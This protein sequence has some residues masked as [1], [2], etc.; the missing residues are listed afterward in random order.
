M[1]G[2]KRLSCQITRAK[3]SSGRFGA[4]AADSIIMHTDSR[5]SAPPARAGGGACGAATVPSAGALVSAGAAGAGALV[6][7]SCASVGAAANSISA[8]IAIRA[9]R[10]NDK[11]GGIV[12]RNIAARA[13]VA[14]RGGGYAIIAALTLLPPQTRCVPLP[15]VGRGSG[16]GSCDSFTG[17]DTEIHPRHPPP[18]PSPP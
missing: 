12:R 9:M 10:D 16:W 7:L 18:H 13:M 8:I 11:A 17:G 3:N 14:K 1:L 15:L 5:R 4:R 2:W 6:S